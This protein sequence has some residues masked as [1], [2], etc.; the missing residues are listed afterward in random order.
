MPL[1]EDQ[2]EDQSEAGRRG[3]D[4]DGG[5]GLYQEFSLGPIAFGTCSLWFKGAI[6]ET[7]A[8]K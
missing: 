3:G 7:W 4:G 8:C 5:G 6:W 2:S 1:P